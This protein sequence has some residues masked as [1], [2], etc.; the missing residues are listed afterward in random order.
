MFVALSPACLSSPMSHSMPVYLYVSLSSVCL[1]VSMPHYL[2]V[3]LSECLYVCHTLPCLYPCLTPICL[4]VRLSFY[5]LHSL[6]VC[7]LVSL[8]SLRLPAF[9][10]FCLS[11]LPPS[12]LSVG[13]RVPGSRIPMTGRSKQSIPPRWIHCVA[14]TSASLIIVSEGK[15]I[16][17]C[18]HHCRRPCQDQNREKR[19]HTLK[20]LISKPR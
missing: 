9:L 11:A 8:P 12:C 20:L 3:C 15:P 7:L 17:S 13:G 10:P 5:M 14:V 2:S 4:Y 16:N 19:H 6:S 1:S 18:H